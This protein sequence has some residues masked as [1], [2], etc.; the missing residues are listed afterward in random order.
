[1]GKGKSLWEKGCS[2][3]TNT[4]TNVTSS[5]GGGEEE[6]RAPFK[7][8]KIEEFADEKVNPKSSHI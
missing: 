1:M 5:D 6:Q 2:S 7:S 4:E 8:A 3:F